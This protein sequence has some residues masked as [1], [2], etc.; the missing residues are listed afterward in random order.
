MSPTPWLVAVT[1]VAVISDAMLLPFYPQFFAARFGVT[2]PSHIGLY[3][4]MCGLVV[5]LALPGWARL[6]RRIGTLRLLLGTQLLAGGLSLSCA[7]VASLPLFWGLSLAMLVAKASYLLVYPYL[8][9]VE[10]QARHATLIGTLSVVVHAGGILG[11]VV[12]GLVLEHWQAAQIFRVMAVSDALQV[13]VCLLLLRRGRVP[14]STPSTPSV[15][16]TSAALLRLGMVMLLFYFSAHLTR[17]F[18]ARYWEMASGLPGELLAGAVFAIPGGVAVALL[19]FDLLGR[20]ASGSAIVLPLAIGLIGLLLQ[21]SGD[22]TA[23]FAGRILFGWALFRVTVRLE[24]RLFQLSTPDRYASDFSKIHI[25]QG[26]GVLIAS[27]SAG[28]LVDAHGLISPFIV[29]AL[30]FALCALAYRLLL[31]GDTTAERSTDSVSART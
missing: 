22:T 30:G 8:M 16:G 10:P 20:R 26:L 11:A 29:A 18:F 27:W 24:L 25:F 28:R 13:V 23:I 19:A 5:M 7:E 2:D 21:T 6:A 9:H 4:A 31:T 15:P 1:A 14:H 17:P 12:G 3:L